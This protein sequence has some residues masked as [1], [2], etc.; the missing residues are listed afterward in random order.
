MRIYGRDSI[1]CEEHR[2][3]FVQLVIL[4]IPDKLWYL[5]AGQGYGRLLRMF[6]SWSLLQSV[7][8]LRGGTE[9]ASDI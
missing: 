1:R 6:S 9:E 2:A 3:P 4:V 8:L 5:R 7:C